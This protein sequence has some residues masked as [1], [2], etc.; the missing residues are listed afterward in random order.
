LDRE[1]EKEGRSTKCKEKRV[2]E[3]KEERVEKETD[4]IRLET[5]EI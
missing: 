1:K 5:R 2:E 4:S 3:C